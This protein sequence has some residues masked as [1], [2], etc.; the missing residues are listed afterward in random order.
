VPH[1]TVAHGS[2]GPVPPVL[3][4]GAPPE[5]LPPVETK[6]L[7]SAMLIPP[8]DDVEPADDPPADNTVPP[9]P[10]PAC[11]VDDDPPVVT[12]PLPPPGT[13]SPGGLLELQATKQSKGA[14]VKR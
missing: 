3:L 1:L 9:V 8:L 5:P 2:L 13:W 14:T 7:P 11:A 10:A 6:E 4:M 12:E